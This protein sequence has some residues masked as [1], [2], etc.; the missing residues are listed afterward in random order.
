M[1][2]LWR[3]FLLA[4][5]LGFCLSQQSAPATFVLKHV[6]LVSEGKVVEDC[7]V[8]WS[9]ER[10]VAAATDAAAPSDA[11]IIDGSGR[12][13]IPGLFDV[14]THLNS[15]AG[16]D[17]R[18]DL[19][20]NLDAYLYY[21]ITTVVDFSGNPEGYGEVRSMIAHGRLTAPHLV[22]AARF[23][24]PLG[25]GAEGGRDNA[26]IEVQTPREARVAME[27]L[28][29]FQPDVLKIFT[30]G[31]RY[32]SAPD[33]TSMDQA[34]LN[35]LVDLAHS[36]GMEVLTHTVTVE[37]AKIAS[38]AG[39][40]CLA[41][42]ASN[43]AVD[44][45]LIRLMRENK[46]SYAPTSAVYEPRQ[47]PIDSPRLLDVMEP[48]LL[49]SVKGMARLDRNEPPADPRNPPGP[50]RSRRF[51][52][53]KANTLALHRAGIPIVLGTDA[54]VTGTFH[55]WASIHELELLCQSGLS[56]M[57][58]LLAGTINAARVLHLD[59][60]GSIAAGKAAD[61][62]LIAGRPDEDIRDIWKMERVF[63]AGRELDRN[64][65]RENI[66]KQE[67]RPP[68]TFRPAAQLDNFESASGRS[69]IGT[70]WYGAF[71]P[72]H[73][74]SRLSYARVLR[75]QSDH[76]LSIH[77]SFAQKPE[78]YASVVI[79]MSGSM[80]R[81]AETSEFTGL[82]F[83]VRGEG[84]YSAALVTALERN[85]AYPVARFSADASW[86]KIRIPFHQFLTP[87]QSAR[88]ETGLD[89][90]AISFQIPGS[91]GVSRWMELDNVQ[92]MR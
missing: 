49:N 72:G 91:P 1:K 46:T 19:Q 42:A 5:A 45:E 68:E 22:L 14:H 43:S 57:D 85:G 28:S 84:D 6:R 59:D 29:S 66:Q 63:H 4:F 31:W 33:M 92:F 40:D 8:V 35:T 51:E 67:T 21:G 60:R 53:L 15:S 78:P 55:G 17:L 79:P 90:L 32:G 82:E 69:L 13:L 3:A 9:A 62:V 87:I 16:Q 88:T 64:S 44:D 37:R 71:D 48:A 73:D 47:P 58:A 30:D 74:H 39:V 52:I 38:R 12:T 18:A 7:S 83:E 54:G 86:K 65:L 25:H 50:S 70:L 27:M 56:P 89:L 61:F 41:H 10:I 23:T 11:T 24:T 75:S 36:R 81:A 26:S 80:L 20:K 34:T 76:A 2:N 77:V